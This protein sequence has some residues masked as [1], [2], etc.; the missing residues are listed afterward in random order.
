MKKDINYNRG[1]F[2]IL[3]TS[4][5]GWSYEDY[6]EWCEDNGREPEGEG[7]DD[8]WEWCR[9][10]ADLEFEA[11]L[12]NINSCKEYNIPVV[13]TGTLGLWWGR[14]EI[15]PMVFDSVFD[16]LMHIRETDICEMEAKFVD[17]EIQVTGLHHDGTNC[18]TIKALSA[19]GQRKMYQ[20]YEYIDNL[21]PVDTK[22]LPYLY[23]I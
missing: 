17:G 2:T 23:A 11:D 10:E 21:K 4:T 5:D 15:K 1:T 20:G 12:V 22:R 3:T 14:P 8:F 7:S 9:E 18:F 6:K 16:A 19:K 13:L